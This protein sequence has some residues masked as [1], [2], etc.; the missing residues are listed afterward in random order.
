VLTLIVVPVMYTLFE[1]ARY[2]IVSAFRGPRWPEAP[3]GE[4]YFF[5]RRRYARMVF[6]LFMLVQLVVLGAGLA[7]FVPPTVATIAQTPF[8]APSLLKLSIEVT[9][10]GLELLL[11]AIGFL[12][13]LLLPTWVGLVW[14]MAKR[15]REGYFVDITPRGVS[16]G[17]PADRYFI[18]KEAITQVKTA[19][20]F[21]AISTISIHSGRRRIILRKLVKANGRPEKT[22]LKTWLAARAPERKLIRESMTDLKRSLEMLAGGKRA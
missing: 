5:S 21:P 3:E 11:T 8:Q 7:F 10:F 19:P 16:I 15:S 2:T 18:E 12:A 14:V 6:G 22:P 13:V 17:T 9:V 1:G 20:F 4:S